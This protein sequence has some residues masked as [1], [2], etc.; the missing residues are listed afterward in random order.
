MF[1]K[2]GD[3]VLSASGGQGDV[4]PAERRE[5]VM[6]DT[7]SEF[8][9]DEKKKASEAPEAVALEKRADRTGYLR[10]ALDSGD[11]KINPDSLAAAMV[12]VVE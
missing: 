4:H 10:E 11:Y 1:P 2:K 6:V 9:V 3:D 8:D 12:D 7:V 5:Y